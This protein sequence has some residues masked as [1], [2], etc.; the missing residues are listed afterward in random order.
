MRE[1]RRRE[2]GREGITEGGMVGEGGRDECTVHIKLSVSARMCDAAIRWVTHEMVVCIWWKVVV[3]LWLD[4]SSFFNIA[5]IVIDFS[6]S[7][8]WSSIYAPTQWR[9][10]LAYMAASS[11][12]KAFLIL[13]SRRI[14]REEDWE[15]GGLVGRRSRREEG[16]GGRKEAISAA[17][18]CLEVGFE[19]THYQELVPIIA[20]LVGQGHKRQQVHLSLEALMMWEM[21]H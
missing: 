13:A 6:V 8:V 11:L 7:G 17:L 18:Q 19:I 15:G 20:C 14:D 3:F 12:N 21:F 1:G 4:C 16:L 2:E 9:T 10:A 5:G